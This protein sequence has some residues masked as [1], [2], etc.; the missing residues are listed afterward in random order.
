MYANLHLKSSSGWGDSAF[1]TNF[2]RNSAI[3][4]D[5]K[6]NVNLLL[7]TNED[8]EKTAFGVGLIVTTDFPEP[9]RVLGHK[10]SNITNNLEIQLGEDTFDNYKAAPKIS[11]NLGFDTLGKRILIAF[12]AKINLQDRSKTG[13][14]L[15]SLQITTRNSRQRIEDDPEGGD[16]ERLEEDIEE[17]EEEEEEDVCP[18]C[19]VCPTPAE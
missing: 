16:W 13:L 11:T 6:W 17:I 2:F 5:Q 7:S 18:V 15:D 12:G 14:I 19:P 3:L 4:A 10:F 8:F 1:G 9:V